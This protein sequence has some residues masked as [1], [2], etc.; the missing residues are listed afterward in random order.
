MK[1]GPREVVLLFGAL[2]ILFAM[3][4]SGIFLFLRFVKTAGPAIAERGPAPAS[5]PAAGTQVVSLAYVA[6]GFPMG[7]SAGQADRFSLAAARPAEIRV[8][9]EGDSDLQYGE[10]PLGGAFYPIALGRAGLYLDANH[11]GD[12]TDD[13]GPYANEGSGVFATTAEVPTA[14]GPY[15]MWFFLSNMGGATYY[16]KCHRA[17]TFPFLREYKMVLYDAQPNGRYDDEPLVIDWNDNGSVEE[18]ESIRVGQDFRVGD[19][20]FRLASIDPAGASVTIAYF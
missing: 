14:S 5:A 7:L 11:N 2:A 1:I 17:G 16:A 8:I 19:R 15:S 6:E 13:R 20:A 4:V 3:F 12:L 9:P 10:L 18:G